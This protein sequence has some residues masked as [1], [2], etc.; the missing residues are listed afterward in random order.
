[1]SA[2]PLSYRSAAH[3]DHHQTPE[4][5]L[6][7]EVVIRAVQDVGLW[8]ALEREDRAAAREALRWLFHPH[9]ELAL[10]DVCSMAGI[11]PP[12]ARKLAKELWMEKL[13]QDYKDVANALW[14][15]AV[16]W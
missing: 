1:M 15:E 4:H 11:D 9:S 10:Y 8:W 16:S 2:P 3:A 6:W 7:V 14:A 13:P 5:A 12:Q